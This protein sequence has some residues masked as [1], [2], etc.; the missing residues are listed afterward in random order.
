V[1]DSEGLGGEVVRSRSR[2]RRIEER[3]VRWGEMG[4]KRDWK[5]EVVR[6][7]RC[8]GIEEVSVV[9]GVAKLFMTS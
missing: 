4:G 7:S 3:G 1:P 9:D 6:D 2:T 5:T 8:L